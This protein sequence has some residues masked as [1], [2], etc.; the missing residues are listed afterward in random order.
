MSSLRIALA[1]LLLLPATRALAAPAPLADVASDRLATVAAAAA[2]GQR[3]RVLGIEV[4]ST[5]ETLALDVERFEVFAPDAEIVVHGESGVRRRRVPATVFFRGGVAGEP[6]SRSF[7]AVLPNGRIQGIVTRPGDDHFLI[8]TAP[9]GAARSGAG[10]RLQA[11]R[12]YSTLLEPEGEGWACEA[13]GL[14]PPAEVPGLDLIASSTASGAGG[15][16]LQPSTAPL[17][18]HTARVAIETDHEFLQLFAGNS[19]AAISYVGN[20]IGYAS[21]IYQSEISTSL[22]VQSVS[23]WSTASDP[24]AQ[25]STTCGLMEFGRYWNKNKT[26]VSRTIAH[27]LSGKALGGGVAWIGALCRGPFSASASCTGI[28]TD[29]PWGGDYGFTASI[30]GRFDINNP[31]VIWDIVAVTHEI[32]HNFNSPHTHCYNGLG[33][34]SSPVDKCNGSSP[35]CYS[36]A[37]SLPG[38]AGSG[39]GTI[40]SYCHLVRGSYSDLS[41]NFGTGHPYGIQPGRVPSRMAAHVAAVASTKPACLAPAAGALIFADGFEASALPGVW[42]DANP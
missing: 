40:M 6:E 10:Q 42:G 12:A 26:G 23:L 30:S 36:G 1:T 16:A 20:L 11:E 13:N 15:D 5:S 28:P 25:S 34:S 29:A 3:L 2:V 27:F 4:P 9:E 21:T 7:L 8:D 19:A 24:W 18:A 14:T 39:S 22:V 37:T 35:G 32:G 41:L 33:G 31:R 17:V 38:P